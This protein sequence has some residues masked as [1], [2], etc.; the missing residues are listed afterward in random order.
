[1]PEPGKDDRLPDRTFF[2]NIAHTIDHD[3]VQKVIQHAND[4][5]MKAGEKEDDHENIVISEAWWDKLNT[6]PF[7]SVSFGCFS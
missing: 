7:V 3:Y 1:M 5:R 4:Q 6:V 2:W